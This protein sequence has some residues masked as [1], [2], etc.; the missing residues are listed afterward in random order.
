MHFD[1]SNRDDFLPIEHTSFWL[2]FMWKCHLAADFRRC[3]RLLFVFVSLKYSATKRLTTKIITMTVISLQTAHIL[4]TKYIY[5]ISI[6]EYIH[7]TIYT[8]G[9]CIR[10]NCA[11]CLIWQNSHGRLFNRPLEIISPLTDSFQL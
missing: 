10:F 5:F 8:M 3:G 2:F 1:I 11:S 7:T 4:L 6:I 9:W